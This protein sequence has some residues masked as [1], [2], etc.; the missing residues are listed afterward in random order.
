MASHL[1]PPGYVHQAH[2]ALDVMAR[3][4]P[5]YENVFGVE[6]PLPKLDCLV[7]TDSDAGA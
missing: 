1:A 6:Y 3:A 4:V 2:F 5:F 7:A